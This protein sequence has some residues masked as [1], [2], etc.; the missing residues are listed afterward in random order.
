MIRPDL[1]LP[2]T[3]VL[4]PFSTEPKA[5]NFEEEKKV[6]VVKKSG[7]LSEPSSKWKQLATPEHAVKKIVP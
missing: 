7:K 1:G 5:V 6:K 4:F 3:L 2:L